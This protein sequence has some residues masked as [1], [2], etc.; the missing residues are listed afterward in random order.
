MSKPISR[1]TAVFAAF[2]LGAIGVGIVTQSQ[3]LP[4]PTDVQSQSGSGATCDPSRV[5]EVNIQYIHD[6]VLAPGQELFVAMD[7]A[8]NTQTYREA[9]YGFIED[10]IGVSFDPN[11]PNPQLTPGGEI[12]MQ[13]SQL[14]VDYQVYSW[15][16][17]NQHQ[18]RHQVPLTNAH[19]KDDGY[20][21]IFL[22]DTLVYGSWGG[23]AGR[24]VPAGS[25][26]LFGEYRVFD[27]Q[28]R[29]ITTIQYQSSDPAT[30]NPFGYVNITCDVFSDLWG[31]GVVY[32]L[33]DSGVNPERHI[34][35]RN[36]MTFAA[37][38]ADQDSTQK[39]K[40]KKLKP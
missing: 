16:V 10:H 9:A 18:W 29:L 14:T 37:S 3:A 4:S 21:A 22:Q 38:L 1:W 23:A 32:G 35:T 26:V 34:T 20:L 19:F 5:Y 13:P 8:R 39:K 15:D 33:S 2:V 11:D 36:V 28:D 31:Q 27:H 30:P 12:L 24:L 6:H 7:A 25:I 17:Q 40:C